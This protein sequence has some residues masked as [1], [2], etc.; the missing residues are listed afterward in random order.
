MNLTP[1]STVLI[2]TFSP[3]INGIRLPI[4]GNV[5]PMIDFFTPRVRKTVLIDQVYPGSESVLPRIEVYEKKKRIHTCTSSWVVRMLEPIL[6][7][8]NRGGTH[9]VFKIRDF[10]SVL[11]WSLRDKELYDFFI[12]FESV[13]A[14]A[15]IL[16]RK[17]GKVSTVIYYVSDYSPNRY[18]NK[19]FN[20]FYLWLD[21]M[22]A[23]Y[24]DVIWDVS[25]AMQPAR[26]S[27]GL[28]PAKSAPVLVV[29]NALYPKQIRSE[30]IERIFYHTIVF[31]GT[32][33]EENGPDIAIKAMTSV[34]KTIPDAVLHIVGGGSADMKRLIN[35]VSNLK[36]KKSIV[37]HGFISDRLK[38][39]TLI[40][41]FQ[42]AVAPY[43]KIEGSA[44]LYGDATKIRAY[45]AAG[46]PTITTDVPPLGKVV[47][48]AGAAIIV[49]DSPEGLARSVVMLFQNDSVYK[50]MKS[51][52]IKFAKDNT[53]DK[54]YTKAFKAMRMLNHS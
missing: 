37:F 19:V 16:L 26:M 2:A 49:P 48:S 13:N 23:R 8:F 50:K 10:L 47:Q 32:L 43:K 51:Q 22:A 1:D 7:M 18:Q 3:W 54:E 33:G 12:G 46:L 40:R 36:L 44:R 30:S 28:D 24:A 9:I 14:L 29:P 42:I 53:W 5:E 39:S 25:P 11:D 20:R 31:M 52:A 38:I 17:L 6:K 15:G 21:K 34:I 45:L 27:V 35:L 4:N 41:R